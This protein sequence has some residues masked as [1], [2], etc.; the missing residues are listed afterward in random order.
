[1]RKASNVNR[2]APIPL[3]KK[4]TIFKLSGRRFKVKDVFQYQNEKKEHIA[5]CEIETVGCK[6][7][8]ILTSSS[9]FSMENENV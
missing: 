9:P 1:M 8:L 6:L 3:L 2:Y 4:G 5:Q 7:L